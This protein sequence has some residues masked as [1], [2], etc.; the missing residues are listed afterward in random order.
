[1]RSPSFKPWFGAANGSKKTPLRVLSKGL[2]LPGDRW[3]DKVLRPFKSVNRMQR[4]RSPEQPW[5]VL[6]AEFALGDT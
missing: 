4:K 5:Q 3:Q 2:T 1:M 6:L